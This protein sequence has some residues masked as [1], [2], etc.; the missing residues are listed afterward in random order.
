[1]ST[2]P[3]RWSLLQFAD[4]AARGVSEFRRTRLSEEVGVYSD[5]F[6]QARAAVEEMLELT[7]DLRDPLP[8]ARTAASTLLHP[9]RYVAAPPIS[10]D[11]LVTLSGAR[12]DLGSAQD[13][14]LVVETV[15][16]VA[17][18]HRFPWLVHGGEPTES[19]KVAAVVA[20]ASAMATQQV[21]TWR[22]NDS[23]RLQENLVKKSLL[24][25]GFV[26]EAA[27]RIRTP[28][29][30][31]SPGALYSESRV[32]EDKFDVVVGLWDDRIL[33]IECKV[34]NSAVNSYKRIKGD[35]ASKAVR[36]LRALGEAVIVPS[37]VIAG[38]YLPANLY[39]AQ[40]AGLVIWWSHDMQ[41]LLDWVRSTKP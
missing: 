30:F 8:Q 20:T 14:E 25:A 4:G 5:Y 22:R 3:P 36:V 32:H 9:L 6:E 37:A 16:K 29:D 15:M 34:S 40:Q 38:V 23:K 12:R 41:Q 13:A 39:E 18:R 27:R 11:D 21:Q 10:T 24:E 31:P 33:C 35:A 7:D 2:S 19:E 1:M 17:D 26:E 28:R